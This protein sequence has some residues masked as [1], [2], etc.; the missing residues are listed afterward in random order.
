M[1]DRDFDFLVSGVE[2]LLTLFGVAT[3]FVVSSDVRAFL[4]EG[5]WSPLTGVLGA[6]ELSLLEG[7]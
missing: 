7:V 5:V 4:L 6:M 2:A 3:P 1:Y